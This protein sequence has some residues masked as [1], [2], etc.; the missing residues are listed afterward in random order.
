MESNEVLRLLLTQVWQVA[1]TAAIVWIV[2]KKFAQNQPQ[3]AHLLWGLVL[4]KVITP[5]IWSSPTSV[6][7]WLGYGSHSQ[8]IVQPVLDNTSPRSGSFASTLTIR[9]QRETETSSRTDD[10]SPAQEGSEMLASNEPNWVIGGM[11]KIW[12]FGVCFLVV[13]SVVRLASFWCWVRGNEHRRKI[14]NQESR[15]AL[16]ERMQAATHATAV[17]LGIY[18]KIRVRLIDAP[19]G[20][21]VVGLFRPTIV[22]P[23]AIVE[24]RSTEFLEPLIAHELLHIR[25]GDLFWAV[26]Q[27]LSTSLLWFHPLVWL[28]ARKLTLESER[29]CDEQTIAWLGC[30]PTAYAQS[31][32]D[33]LERK[34][35]LRVAPAL[36]GVRPVDITRK[37][38]E[39]VM[40][41]GQGC[42]RQSPLWAWAIFAGAVAVVIPGAAF[43]GAQDV[44][45]LSRPRAQPT[46]TR[47]T[48]QARK[49]TA[50]QIVEAQFVVDELLE[51]LKASGKSDEQ[52]QNTLLSLLPQSSLEPIRRLDKYGNISESKNATFDGTILKVVGTYEQTMKVREAIEERRHF[53][54]GKTSLTVRFITIP[55]ERMDQLEIPWRKA[56]ELP[57][58]QFSAAQFEDG[59]LSSAQLAAT[60]EMPQPP[61]APRQDVFYFEDGTKVLQSSSPAEVQYPSGI[62]D[63][64]VSPVPKNSPSFDAPK[65]SE[66]QVP[67]MPTP[68]FY[69]VVADDACHE[70]LDCARS[71]KRTNVLQAPLVTAFYGTLIHI[72]DTVER[73]FVTGSSPIQGKPGITEKPTIEVA[74]E[75]IKVLTQPAGGANGNVELLFALNERRIQQIETFTYDKSVISG[76]EGNDSKPGKTVQIPQLMSRFLALKTSLNSGESLFVT[77]GIPTL[78]ASKGGAD[79][80]LIAVV[81]ASDIRDVAQQATPEGDSVVPATA[82]THNQPTPRSANSA[83]EIQKRK[84]KP[85]HERYERIPVVGPITADGPATAL[86]PPTD[87]EILQAMQK[88]RRVSGDNLESDKIQR[89]NVLIEKEKIADYVDPPRFVPLVGKAS[90]HHAHYKCPVYFTEPTTNRQPILNSALEDKESVEVVYIVH[91]HSHVVSN[92]ETESET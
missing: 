61:A 70:I 41:L 82:P 88:L 89:Y 30:S 84:P 42:R 67:A 90:L 56:T 6:F 3:M 48:L 87:D 10:A 25:R 60:I 44:A 20:P 62:A 29:S 11:L 76:F 4:L 71:D 59:S 73:C 7:S 18:R 80:V 12:I 43:V 1:L 52:A 37:R 55:K 13:V 21:A 75:G 51:S 85:E 23:L 40:R 69:A 46:E 8:Q 63:F 33:V 28:A 32:I 2:T 45:D 57:E 19:I 79:E 66:L 35:Q 38:L 22:L 72:N 64:S 49:S 81:T 50:T 14:S 36:P 24:N 26:L 15:R 9:V 58:G 27:T 31:L 47:K 92:P 68:A 16:E 83:P 39:R 17:K 53:G 91:N 65:L 5:P 77:S 54:F 78:E 74:V 86:D 34:H